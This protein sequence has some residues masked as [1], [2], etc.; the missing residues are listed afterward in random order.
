LEKN[1]TLVSG[2]PGVI[3]CNAY[4]KYCGGEGIDCIEENQNFYAS[5]GTLKRV[6]LSDFEDF[7][8]NCLTCTKFDYYH[9]SIIF[10]AFIFCQIFNEY[11]SRRL[12]DEKNMFEGVFTNYIFILVTLISIGCQIFLIEVGGDFVRTS[13]LTINEWLITIG[14]GA[15]TIPLGFLQRFIPIKEDPNSFF[16]NNVHQ[17]AVSGNNNY[18]KIKINDE[19][20]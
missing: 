6:S 19:N 10:N 8:S 7:E 11:N 16:D 9:G 12:F 17:V 15:I 2:A 20:A 4:Q 14:L 18:R 3:G 1:S 13:P 5:D